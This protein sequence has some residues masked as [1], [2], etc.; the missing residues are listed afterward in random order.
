MYDRRYARS[1]LMLI[2][3]LLLLGCATT[4]RYKGVAAGGNTGN[5]LG[6]V[7]DE[8][9]QVI[10]VAT[11]SAAHKAG[12]VVGDVLVSLTWVLSEAPEELPNLPEGAASEEI[13]TTTTLR[14]PPGVEN[15]T[16][17]FTDDTAIRELIAY[18][19]PLRLQVLRQGEAQELTIVPA[20]LA[21]EVGGS[22]T[23]SGT[24]Y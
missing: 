24:A 2:I 4:P 9:R 21:Q 8:N 6:V 14:P 12:V 13:T 20:P 15:K 5:V 17:A 19:V 1:L 11:G 10:E 7:L 3:A 16:I 23:S 22:A 18:G